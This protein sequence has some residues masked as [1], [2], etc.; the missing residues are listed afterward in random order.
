MNTTR[1]RGRPPTDPARRM[2]KMNVGVHP[3]HRAILEQIAAVH[4]WTRSEALREILDAY[5]AEAEE[6]GLDEAPEARAV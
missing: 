5:L 2:I 3:W 6:L 4:G 1:R